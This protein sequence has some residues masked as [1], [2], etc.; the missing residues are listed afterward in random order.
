LE[1]KGGSVRRQLNVTRGGHRKHFTR[2]RLEG[3]ARILAEEDIVRTHGAEE[4][5]VETVRDEKA[6][7][8]IADVRIPFPGLTVRGDGEAVTWF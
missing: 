5:G 4:F 3:G 2:V 7:A 1:T 6:K 8:T